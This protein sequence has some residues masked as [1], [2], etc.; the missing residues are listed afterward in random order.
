MRLGDPHLE[1]LRLLVD[2]DAQG[3][4]LSLQAIAEGLDLNSQAAAGVLERLEDDGLIEI[5]FGRGDDQIVSAHV[6]R[7]T[8][9]AH[10][11]LRGGLK[12]IDPSRTPR[13]SSVNSRDRSRIFIS[14]ARQDR[15]LADSLVDLLRLG[16]DIRREQ[17]FQSERTS[18]TISVTS[19][20]TP[21]L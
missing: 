14:H 7:V 16:T 3:V 20:E 1:A 8:S 15:N 18:L 10:R 4:N 17:L 21:P 19:Y 6:L 9:Q 2:A 5:R 11:V 12:P 13:E